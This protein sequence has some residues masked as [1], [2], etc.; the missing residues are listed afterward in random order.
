MNYFTLALPSRVFLCL[1][2]IMK[3][4]TALKLV[5]RKFWSQWILTLDTLT[6]YSNRNVRV[7]VT[8]ERKSFSGQNKPDSLAYSVTTLFFLTSIPIQIG[9]A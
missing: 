2:I 5:S 6:G 9:C 4:R 1:N 3:I 7:G 8:H